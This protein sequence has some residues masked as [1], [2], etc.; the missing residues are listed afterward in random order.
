MRVLA[1]YQCGLGLNP[2]PGIISGLS[3][4]LVLTLLTGFCY[5][6]FSGFPLFTKAK[7]LSSE[8]QF[9]SLCDVPLK[10]PIYLFICLFVCLFI[11]LFVYM[12]TN[13][14]INGS[15]LQGMLLSF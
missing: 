10:I 7:T 5:C 11:H 6:W 15:E 8:F 12:Y 2:R 3:L 13:M 14:Y 1:S 4:L 9:A